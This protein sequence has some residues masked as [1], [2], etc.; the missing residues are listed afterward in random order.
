MSRFFFVFKLPAAC[1]KEKK[2][3]NNSIEIH[4]YN[5]DIRERVAV[6]GS[7]IWYTLHNR[8]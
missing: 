1:C 8:K 7:L 3:K 4:P 2:K 5:T 6:Q